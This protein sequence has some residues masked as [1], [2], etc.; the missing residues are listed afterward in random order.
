MK[1]R[2]V[3]L[4]II[5][6]LIFLMFFGYCSMKKKHKEEKQAITNSAASL[7]QDTLEKVQTRRDTFWKIRVTELSPD[8]IR[9]SD[10]YGELK[11]EQ[12]LLLAEL[13]RYKNLVASMQVQ[14]TGVKRDTVTQIIRIPVLKPF[15]L[16]WQDTAGGFTYTD[17]VYIDSNMTHRVFTPRLAFTPDVRIMKNRKGEV[18]AELRVMGLEE[19]DLTAQNVYSFYSKESPADI[20]RKRFAKAAKVAGVIGTGVLSFYA[21]TK[22]NQ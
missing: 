21:G 2:H 4:G 15:Y 11:Y 19:F 8:E 22:V 18:T 12:Q 16:T 5:V 7:L 3:Y 17:T 14:F 20:R 10:I 13:A 9:K 1:E 6:I